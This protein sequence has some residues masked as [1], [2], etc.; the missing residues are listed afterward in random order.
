MDNQKMTQTLKTMSWLFRN[1]FRL[2]SCRYSGTTFKLR[3]S[4]KYFKQR[5]V[6]VHN[7]G[8][9]LSRKNW[10]EIRSC[11]K[12]WQICFS[13]TSWCCQERHDQWLMFR[14][15]PITAGGNDFFPSS[16]WNT[17]RFFRTDEIC[18]CSGERVSSSCFDHHDCF[19]QFHVRRL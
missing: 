10:K 7:Q 14:L 19:W 4:V 5:K 8:N 2:C 18:E 13:S 15:R 16:K 6:V 12:V 9:K 11:H 17:V 3:A 1:D